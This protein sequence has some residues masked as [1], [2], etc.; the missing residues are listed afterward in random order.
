L[1]PLPFQ[2][3]LKIIFSESKNFSRKILA[4]GGGVDDIFSENKSSQNLSQNIFPEIFKIFS[5]QILQIFENFAIPQRQGP[6]PASWA[7]LFYFFWGGCYPPGGTALIKGWFG[8]D[9]PAYTQI[10]AEHLLSLKPPDD[11]L[12]VNV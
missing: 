10:F 2:G 8:V 3:P 6:L 7:P 11:R 4:T 5:Q 9:I 1:G 12:Y